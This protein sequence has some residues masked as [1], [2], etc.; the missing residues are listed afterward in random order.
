MQAEA[1]FA[2]GLLDP[3]APV[4]EQVRDQAPRRYA[5][6]RNNVTVG[7]VKALEANFPAVRRLLGEA[8]FAGL[9]R[10]FAQRHPPESPL[11]FHYGAAFPAYLAAQDD[12]SGF[13]YLADVARVEQG[14]RRAYHAADVQVLEAA[15]LALA[16][17]RLMTLRFKPHP[18]TFVLAS[19]YAVHAILSANRGGDGVVADPARPQAVLITRPAHDVIVTALP[20]EQHAFLAALI[21]GAQLAEAA[22]RGFAAGES[23]D[24]AGTIRLMVEAGV[25]QSLITQ[26]GT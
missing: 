5:V 15:D 17:D 26:D 12:L 7:L 16:A 1:R 20:A 19:S 6:Y 14:W 10:A 13:P 4:P 8:Y 9:A 24:L 2:A 18:A 21:D 22:E 23:F 25:F 11:L 3:S